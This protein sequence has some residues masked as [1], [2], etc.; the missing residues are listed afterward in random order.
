MQRLQT[1]LLLIIAGSLAIIAFHSLIAP[2]AA[3]ADSSSQNLY[4]EPGATVLRAPDGSQQV[5]GKVV[6]DMNTGKIWGF[7][8][9]GA[10][11]YP[12]D[13]TRTTP[14]TSQPIFLG[15]FDLSAIHP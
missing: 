10:Q 3:R 12:V 9:Y 15:K 14:P 4:V 8:T 5:N 2:T 7:P 11:P 1:F 6:I 13:N